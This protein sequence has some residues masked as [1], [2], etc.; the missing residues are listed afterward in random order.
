MLERHSI[1]IWPSE[2]KVLHR[3]FSWLLELLLLAH[4][5]VGEVSWAGSPSK[6]SRGHSSLELIAHRIRHTEWCPKRHLRAMALLL[7]LL[8]LL[9]QEL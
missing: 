4:V 2:V 8:H 1:T 7:L 5:H 9:D 6:E 3:M